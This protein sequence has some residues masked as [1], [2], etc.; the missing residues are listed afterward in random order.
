MFC[1]RLP[2]NF[3]VT[4]YF[5]GNAWDFYKNDQLLILKNKNF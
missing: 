2:D 3:P 1:W 4:F 5:F